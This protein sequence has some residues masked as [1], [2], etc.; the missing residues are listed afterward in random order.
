MKPVGRTLRKWR[1]SKPMKH[2]SYA[3]KR[4]RIDKHINKEIEDNTKYDK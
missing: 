2:K 3:E 4:G 1:K